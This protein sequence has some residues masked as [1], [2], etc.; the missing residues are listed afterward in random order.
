MSSTSR[1]TSPFQSSPAT[2][3]SYQEADFMGEPVVHPDAPHP[4]AE[5]AIADIVDWV[6]KD[7]FAQANPSLNDDHGMLS[8]E[9][10]IAEDALEPLDP[11]H[12]H[13]HTHLHTLQHDD[14]FAHLGEMLPQPLFPPLEL[15]AVAGASADPAKPSGSSA[16]TLSR[17]SCNDLL[18]QVPNLPATGAKSRVET[19][20]R[21]ELTL[22]TLPAYQQHATTA[23]EPWDRVSSWP[24]LKLPRGSATKRRPRKEPS[25]LPAAQDVLELSVDVFCVSNPD[26]PVAICESCKER[27]I[28]RKARKAAS[29]IRPAKNEDDPDVG[30]NSEPQLVHF[31][32][33]DLIDFSTG[34]AALPVRI[35]CYC[36]HHKE[37]SGFTLVFSLRDAD[38]RIVGRGMTPPVMITDDHKSNKPRAPREPRDAQS[39]SAD[40]DAA[41]DKPGSV[42]GVDA[43]QRG[44]VKKR[45]KPY[46]RDRKPRVALSASPSVQPALP[47]VQPGL[48][49]TA[50]P[51]PNTSPSLSFASPTESSIFNGTISP[52][53]LPINFTS[54][55][56]AALSAATPV[57]QSGVAFS[58]FPGLFGIPQPLAAPGV[59]QDVPRIQRLVPATGPTYGGIEVTILGAGFSSAALSVTFGGTPASSTTKWSDNTLVCMLPPRATPGPVH[60]SVQRLEDGAM[61]EEDPTNAGST[62]HYVEGTDRDL[63]EL[64]LK[65]VSINL[66]GRG[67]MFNGKDIAHRIISDIGG[68]AV[69]HAAS[70]DP[71]AML[72]QLG[73]VADLQAAILSLFT[74]YFPEAPTA[75]SST[76]R[77]AL[78]HKSLTGQ[79]VLHLAT[80]LNMSRLVVWLLQRGVDVNAQ[81]LN[82]FTPLHFAVLA[83]SRECAA[84]LFRAGADRARRTRTGLTPAALAG[85]WVSNLIVTDSRDTTP[86]E[87]ADDE[88]WNSSEEEEDEDAWS[89]E[90]GFS[91]GSP[92]L[93]PTSPSPSSMT[94]RRR[95]R[96]T[97]G[98]ESSD[99]EHDGGE[100]D[101]LP[102]ST[103]A[104]P[105]TT[106]A[107][108][109]AANEKQGYRWLQKLANLPGPPAFMPNVQ[110]PWDWA[111][112]SQQIPVFYVPV[113]WRWPG[114]TD[115]KDN[116]T[117]S[118]AQSAWEKWTPQLLMSPR[119]PFGRAE[120]QTQEQ[121]QQAHAYPPAQEA[122]RAPEHP[123][124]YARIARSVAGY[125]PA[126][127]AEL[128]M[129]SYGV[130]DRR[131][132]RRGSQDRML[133]WFWLPMLLLGLFWVLYA[134]VPL[135]YS[136]VY[137]AIKAALPIRE[138]VPSV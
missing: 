80:I 41:A 11:P 12:T 95:P 77:S 125:V 126:S 81:D 134:G 32:C 71:R 106:S 118:P 87:D 56:P 96:V 59:P 31:N 75:L 114:E 120:Q 20:I 14:V 102:P 19:Q 135:A 66:H 18:I 99:G 58:Q 127:V 88:D 30:E 79:N 50:P 55:H 138:M 136:T 40:E 74:V 83:G 1:S 49:P 9:D 105:P 128:E 123:H 36:R 47:A 24:W 70:G 121:E 3:E 29:R 65:I 93:V 28:K 85:D 52:S 91:D 69:L 115:E 54:I 67:N 90:D 98:S 110:V 57:Q 84:T 39:A 132:R 4:W 33:P 25:I 78:T 45:S 17:D 119:L 124:M 53:A 23:I 103:P 10:L 27:E 111:S 62:F 38:G 131:L 13:T 8:L 104:A 48:Y 15:S 117:V 92:T 97:S 21:M 37:K 101:D 108:T 94:R 6:S 43:A 107:A 122:A 60:V 5:Q 100:L 72:L 44:A 46:E 68:T 26:V 82:G 51:S 113:N 73:N 76:Q 116:K 109:A 63:M 129:N 7:V 22:T 16:V 137:R 130:A 64:A 42:R 35:T 112:L 34:L 2:P 61:N 89:D 86:S 133:L